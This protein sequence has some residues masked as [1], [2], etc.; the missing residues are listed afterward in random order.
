MDKKQI[1]LGLDVS[2]TCIG[3]S[4]ASYDG[5]KIEILYV[6]YVKFKTSKKYKGTNSLFYK[7]E[8]FKEQ[9]IGKI[10]EWGITDIV[11]E[12]PLSASQNVVTVNALMKFNGMISQL[13]YDKTGIMPQYISSYN[14][15]KYGFPDLLAVRKYNKKEEPYEKRKILKS[16]KNH[17]VVSF[18]SYPYSCLKKNILWNKIS[19]LYP[20]IKWSFDKEGELC[21]ENFDASDAIVCIL[22][23]VNHTKY[24]DEAP[25]VSDINVTEN[26]NNTTTITYKI[27]FCGQTMDKKNILV[28]KK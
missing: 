19:E 28:D 8:Q 17:E 23:Y 20:D 2:T 9:F 5:E 12:E 15:R 25:K 13:I 4:V 22:G 24:G 21:K 16:L 6:D 10:T 27:T 18:G 14:A 26:D 1:I 11:I 3:T 7:I